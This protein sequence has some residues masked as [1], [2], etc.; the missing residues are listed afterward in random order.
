VSDFQT[1]LAELQAGDTTPQ[2]AR[3]WIREAL[4]RGAASEQELIDELEGAVAAERL[5][6]ALGRTLRSQINAVAGDLAADRDDTRFGAPEPAGEAPDP[7]A[8]LNLSLAPIE[9]PPS[10]HE[11]EEANR[12]DGR[13]SDSSPDGDD[14]PQKTV[15]RFANP[16]APGSARAINKG[17][18]ET[19]DVT[20]GGGDDPAEPIDPEAT[21]F[22]GEAEETTVVNPDAAGTGD[23]SETSGEDW[24]GN[25]PRP[26]RTLGPGSVLKGRFEL[27]APIG[28]G[29]MGTVYKARDLLK[30]EAKD[31]NPYMAVKLL[32]GDFRKHP[33]AFIA[34]QRES[35]K[36]QKLAH[37][38][39]ATVYDFDRDG[40]TVYMTMELMEG[41]ELAK[42]I[43]QLP[44]GGLSL[45]RAMKIIEQLCHGL[46]Y[47]HARQLVHSDFKPGN[48]FITKDGTVKL[49]DFGIARASK[50][51]KNAEG[52]T[53]LFDPGTLGALTPAYATLEMFE[54]EHPDPRD[55]IY[56][57]AC[58]SYEL[59]TGK[60]PFN[61][62]SAVKV[63]EKGLAPAPVAKLNKRQNK[64]LMNALAVHRQDRTPSVEQFW[65]DL[66]TKK[67]HTPQ[68]AAAAVAVL[69]II[70]ALGYKP[71]VDYLQN[72][73][74]TQLV[75]EIHTGT[76]SG[77][78]D[79]LGKLDSLDPD[80][81]RDVLDRAKNDLINYFEARAE[82]QIDPT[83][84][85]YGYPKALALMEQARK[86]YPDS[87]QIQ[88]IR[89]NLEQRRN[90]LVLKTQDQFNNLLEKGRL[91]P[92]PDQADITDVI[93]ILSQAAPDSPLLDDARLTTRYADMAEAALKSDHLDRARSVIDVS[94][95]Y[96]PSD[97][98]LLNLQ[99]QIDR[100]IR[101]RQEHQR[102]AELHQTLDKAGK[103]DSLKALDAIREN[104]AQ[105]LAL[106]P[107]DTQ[108]DQLASQADKLVADDVK[109]LNSAK[110][111]DAAEN[112]LEQFAPVMHVPAILTQR[113]ELSRAEVAA[114]YTPE[115]ISSR[116]K[117]IGQLRTAITASLGKAEFTPKSNAGLLSDYKRLAAM[118]MTGND[119]FDS[120][121]D[122]IARAF[123]GHVDSLMKADRFDAAQSTLDAAG[124]F[125]PG[126]SRIAAK[127]KTLADA[128][129]D[130]H[131]KQQA[132]I[133]HARLEAL[134]NQVVTAAAAD[135]IRN[136]VALFEQVKKE[137]PPDDP[138]VT[139]TGPQKIARSY[140]RLA[141]ARA[142]SGDFQNAITL[143]QGGLALAPDLDSLQAALREFQ[144]DK[145]RKDLLT[146]AA[147]AKPSDMDNLV[148]RLDKLRQALPRDADKLTDA[149]TQRL[150]T[151]VKSLAGND[152]VL[153][154][155]VLDASR[156]VF[157][158]NEQ[159]ASLKIKQPPR[160]SP[161]A[162]DI[163]QALGD[164]ELS[165][166]ESL[167][168]KAR[169][170]PDGQAQL[171][172]LTQEVQNRED[173]ANRY[174]LQYQQLIHLQQQGQARVYLDEAIKRWSDNQ[175]YLAE[176]RHNYQ[177]STLP[178][179]AADGSRP[180]TAG[181]AG[182]GRK[183][184]AEC[185]DMAGS[186]VK[187]PPLVV[188][189]AG[190]AIASPFAIGKYEIS[191]ADFNRYCDETGDCKPHNGGQQLPAVNVSATEAEGY[192]NWLSKATGENYRLPSRKEWIYAATAQG[193][194][195]SRDFNCRVSLG[196]QLIK[197]LSLLEVQVGTPNQWGLIN[198]VGNAQ[199][200]A[201]GSGKIYAMGGSYQDSL[202][203]CSTTLARASS[204]DA[205]PV[206]GFRVV[207]SLD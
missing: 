57:L 90:N 97:A 157:P 83:Q 119:W 113:T 42:F 206:T 165:K 58:V 82:S 202:S 169:Q 151:R 203:T 177:T 122:R 71:V 60:H 48:V 104:L 171:D 27:V 187:G 89:A 159:L 99:D 162:G 84:G 185:F 34:L 175:Q 174:Y 161:L 9:E 94:L 46:A 96:S 184:R 74:N 125:L 136:A 31:R 93:G 63:K 12:P 11:G 53:T 64:A 85:K 163:R 139:T 167:I 160:P 45:D 181:L 30:V 170:L 199:E 137:L 108:A 1:L 109:R 67:S 21:V 155:A 115:S 142:D 158:D 166:A 52:E 112:T 95:K 69:A 130:F 117:Q 192:A 8:E 106:R 10:E 18:P 66:R 35:S 121:Q 62:L 183:G 102:V 196:D 134:E 26:R 105:L 180:C 191:N 179:R 15:R 28:A 118:Q 133:R 150:V 127:H 39:I 38:N 20:G 205:S 54:G 190:G 207:R 4:T 154:N 135:E 107:N 152:L 55:D 2:Q 195:A 147:T 68:I 5:D 41:Q 98:T 188:I 200:W 146:L 141:R 77:V 50:T 75:Q 138:F 101:Q 70:A 168:Q 103:P 204:G 176:R 19:T 24:S 61:K 40:N 43:K 29:G 86:F 116:L 7:F 186:G 193:G 33:E 164:H 198:Y 87:A 144:N 124:H 76:T 194:G 80:S 72:R 78:E 49:L 59:L 120:L 22:A 111:W 36:A 100:R 25:R 128:A 110:R 79:A 44:A 32:S 182:Y 123:L 126:D 81:R 145:Q 14:D 13:S 91:M 153:A 189:P 37:P 173:E 201:L 65:E 73:E 178:A 172:A 16:F 197:G 56:A 132:R 3:D 129:A 88:S 51:Q 156:K 17:D 148:A 143:A 149:V 47:A 6:D 140:L 131:R 23:I 114:G 92:D